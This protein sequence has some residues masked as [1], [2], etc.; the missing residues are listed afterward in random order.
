MQYF[1]MATGITGFVMAELLPSVSAVNQTA[2][3]MW[4]AQC[5]SGIP[6][7]APLKG[8]GSSFSAWLLS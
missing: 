2:Q 6:V 3:V 4:G 7:L 8:S 5:S 1:A